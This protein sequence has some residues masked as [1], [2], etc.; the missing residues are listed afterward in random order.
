MKEINAKWRE[1]SAYFTQILKW[2]KSNLFYKTHT[3]TLTH[4]DIPRNDEQPKK[5]EQ[6]LFSYSSY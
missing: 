6:F 3:N 1:S 2:I 5:K 4:T